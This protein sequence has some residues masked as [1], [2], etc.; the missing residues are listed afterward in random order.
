ME[1]GKINV[2]L[3]EEDYVSANRMH[4]ARTPLIALVVAA[5]FIFGAPAIPN[6]DISFSFS[7]LIASEAE[8]ALIF[9]A[10]VV[11]MLGVRFIYLPMRCRRIFRQQKALHAPYELT[12]NDEGIETVSASWSAKTPWDDLLKWRKNERMFVLYSS[13]VAFK[14]VP[15]RC[16]ESEAELA[17]FASY[18]PRKI[19]PRPGRKRA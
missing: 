10:L 7:R 1:M 3:N 12:W 4:S 13:S 2:Q 14:M 16:F 19:A 9:V 5:I 11:F 15:K 18:L 8:P 6:P 17:D